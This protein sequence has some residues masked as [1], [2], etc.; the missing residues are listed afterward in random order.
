MGSTAIAV[1]IA[2]LIGS[3]PAVARPWLVWA[4]PAFLVAMAGVLLVYREL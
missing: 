1:G 2:L 3:R 4:W